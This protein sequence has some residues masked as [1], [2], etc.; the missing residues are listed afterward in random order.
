[1]DSDKNKKMKLKQILH[2][3][4]FNVCCILYMRSYPPAIFGRYPTLRHKYMKCLLW[5][6]LYFCHNQ[7][8][9][10]LHVMYVSYI[11]M[12]CGGIVILYTVKSLC[13]Y[14]QK[15][16]LIYIQWN[17]K[18]KKYTYCICFFSSNK[19]KNICGENKRK[20]KSHWFML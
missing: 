9:Y 11:S 19:H 7:H 3:K 12:W 14:Q 2:H 5:C 17:M 16:Q 15:Q 8:T 13:T 6:V 4:I 10:T 1:M 20:L 18:L